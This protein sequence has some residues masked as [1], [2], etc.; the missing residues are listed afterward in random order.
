M[1]I[2]AWTPNL[3]LR[4]GT[5]PVTAC[6]LPEKLAS[7]VLDAL[8]LGVMLIS[9]GRVLGASRRF[10]ELS[11]V[12]QSKL[13]Q[14][15]VSDVLPAAA[16]QGLE[17]AQLGSRSVVVKGVPWTLRP[18]SFGG[19]SGLGMDFIFG[20]G[21]E[22]GQFIVQIAPHLDHSGRAAAESFRR[23]LAWVDSLAA[24]IAHEIR[25][26]LGGI[27][28]AAQLLGRG[29]SPDDLSE[30]TALI[31]QES[32]RIDGLVERLMGLTR[33]RQLARSAVVLNQL[34]HDEIALLRAERGDA[35][36]RWV[37]DLDPSLP[38]VEGD[39]A[40]LREGLGNII[41][42]AAEAAKST[43]TLRSRIELGGR[44]S[45]GGFD[46]GRC[47]RIDV[48]DDGPG[49]DPSVIDSVFAP[50]STTKPE[51]SGLGL[52]I[53]RQVIDDHAGRLTLDPQIGEGAR[54]TLIL[55]ERLPPVDQAEDVLPADFNYG[56]YPVPFNRSQEL[57]S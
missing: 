36:P 28:G 26:P 20:P 10:E 27:R 32:D 6:T 33:P 39:P 12:P 37:L 9:D 50:F 54:F 13:I 42:N 8:Q 47:L 43:V 46:R 30:L 35:P 45:E 15:S 5:P 4:L 56:R 25:N 55:A 29:A 18:K 19:D 52:F 23:R 31:I 49:V 7:D 53:A 44:L 3:N 16:L 34:I 1:D 2:S 38:V 48:C 40:R 51:G 11:G 22:A 21:P 14:M 24:G 41:R 57:T 17:R